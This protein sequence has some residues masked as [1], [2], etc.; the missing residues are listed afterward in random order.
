MAFAAPSMTRL[1]IGA[2]RFGVLVPLARTIAGFL[3]V[4][5][6]VALVAAAQLLWRGAAP[7]GARR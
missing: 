7:R 1:L 4:T 2:G 5:R 6:A 3:V